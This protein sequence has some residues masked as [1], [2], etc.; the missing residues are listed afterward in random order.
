MPEIDWSVVTL[1]QTRGEVLD[2]AVLQPAD[3]TR[4]V[5]QHASAC[6]VAQWVLA[7]NRE[8]FLA[9]PDIVNLSVY[10]NPDMIDFT[11]RLASGARDS[12]WYS[13]EHEISELIRDF[14]DLAP[15]Y[16]WLSPPMIASLIP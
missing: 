11:V 6:L 5:C 2:W 3:D 1:P 14:D 4:F 8:Q 15:S 9:Q 12:T 13:P 7:H 10:V 16:S